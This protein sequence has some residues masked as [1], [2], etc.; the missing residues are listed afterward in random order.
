MNDKSSFVNEAFSSVS[1][2]YDLMNNLISFGLH[3]LWKKYACDSVFEEDLP[4]LHQL[5]H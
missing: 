3:H 5:S 1:S 2:R 4:N